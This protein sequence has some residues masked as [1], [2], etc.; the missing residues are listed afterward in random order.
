[1]AKERLLLLLWSLAVL[2]GSRPVGAVARM[3]QP[4]TSKPPACAMPCCQAGKAIKTPC[5]CPKAPAP[6]PAK[7]TSCGCL[8]RSADDGGREAPSALVVM[9]KLIV[10]VPAPLIAESPIPSRAPVPVHL[11]VPR[12]RAPESAEPSLR[13]PPAR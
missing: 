4:L 12:I 6:V 9:T 2:I 8:V 7:K 11:V 5:C 10:D 3:A 13:A 1:M